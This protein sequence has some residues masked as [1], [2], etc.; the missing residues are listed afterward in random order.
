M[1]TLMARCGAF[2]IGDV[3][4]RYARY[5]SPNPLV[6]VAFFPLSVLRADTKDQIAVF[7]SRG[8]CGTVVRL[9]HYFAL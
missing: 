9:R 7:A 1:S 5:P 2:V 3:V 8:R 6:Q 4:V